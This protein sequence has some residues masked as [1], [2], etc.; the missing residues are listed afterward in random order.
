VES[1]QVVQ[2]QIDVTPPTSANSVAGTQ[3]GGGWYT[4][5]VTVLLSG[6]DSLSGLAGL[7]YRLDGGAW[8]PYAGAYLVDSEGPH[9]VD[10]R[11]TD[12]AGN[13][14][15]LHSFEFKID[16]VAPEI[17]ISAPTAGAV[18]RGTS[19]TATWTR[20]DAGSGID[21]C[22]VGIDG[23]I[24]VPSGAPTSHA[25]PDVAEGPHVIAVTCTDVAGNHR[26]SSVDFSVTS[27]FGGP[28]D[29]YLWPALLLALFV[30]AI[31]ILFLAVGRRRRK[32]ET[33]PAAVPPVTETAEPPP[34][35]AEPAPPTEPFLPPPPPPDD[36]PP[37][38]PPPT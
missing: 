26:A 13:V 33:P 22:T 15:A 23:G 24:P 17:A 35:P 11:A 16:S 28:L 32:E 27:G 37:P 20:S 31:G 25:F 30:A 10:F 2:F 34:P 21:G 8:T 7:A 14:E 18:V 6:S 38:P 4:S 36:P 9:S 12:V 5:S 3:G 29:A 19:V 1:V